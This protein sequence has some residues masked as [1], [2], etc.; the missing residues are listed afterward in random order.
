MDEPIVHHRRFTFHESD[1]EAQNF[2]VGKLQ[3]AL[4]GRQ[5]NVLG[6]CDT[7]DIQE[8]VAQVDIPDCRVRI[9]FNKLTS[10]GNRLF[11]LPKAG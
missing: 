7:T 1:V 9:D 8:A 4:A 3:L 6:F 2:E 10:L 5:D 11:S